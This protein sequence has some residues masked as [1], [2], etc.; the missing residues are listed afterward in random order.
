M[1][2]NNQ[3]IVNNKSSESCHEGILNEGYAESLGDVDVCD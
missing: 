3:N 1:L 2:T